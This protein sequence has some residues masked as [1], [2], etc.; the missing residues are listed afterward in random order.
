MTT[1]HL[2]LPEL[3]ASQSQKHVTHN[4]ALEHL[5]VV[6]Q[7]AVLDK[8]LSTP[9]GSPSTGDRYI[10]GASATDDWTGK[11]NEVAY[12]DGDGWVFKTPKDGWF[13]WVDDESEIYFYN[14]GWSALGDVL[15]ADYL[16]LAGGTLTGALL[17]QMAAPSLQ[18]ETT[19]TSGQQSYFKMEGARTTTSSTIAQLDFYNNGTG[20]EGTS[21]QI[22]V[23]GD[24]DINVSIGTLKIS[25]QEIY[26]P[27]NIPDNIAVGTGDFVVSQSNGGVNNVI[28]WDQS[29][30][31]L[32]LGTL[33]SGAGVIE[34]R[35]DI[36]TSNYDLTMRYGGFGGATAD[37]TNRL[38]VNSSDILFNNAGAGSNVKVNKN[39]AGDDASFTFQTGFTTYALF[40][41]LAN[42]DFTLKVGTGFTTAVLIDNTTGEVEMP[43]GFSTGSSAGV[44]GGKTI[45]ITGEEGGTLALNNYQSLGNGDTNVKGVVLPFAAKI[46]AGSM[47][48]SGGA[49]TSANTMT[50]TLDGV[51]Q[52]SYTVSGTYS[53]SGNDNFTSDWSGSPLSVSAGVAINFQCTAAGG[54]ADVVTTIFVV[55]D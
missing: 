32:F 13:C 1:T 10:V 17:Q 39:A 53:G 22:L 5:D 37:A 19:A 24:G 6:V 48:I 31:K 8:D 3:T 35:A 18:L 2:Q 16:P 54:G 43:E 15:G 45:A 52:A 14:A 38:S 9:P 12:Y 30:D 47:S 49:A 51:Q 55:F 34:P 7:L 33:G 50:V 25:D 20:V 36:V 29:N 26:H 28:W 27:G 41:L 40:G 46:Y 42:N 21:A 11:E 4:E 23:D 44:L